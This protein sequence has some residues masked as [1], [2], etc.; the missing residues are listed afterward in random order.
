MKTSFFRRKIGSLLALLFIVTG[1]SAYIASTT[2][3]LSLQVS[4]EATLDKLEVLSGSSNL[5]SGF[6]SDKITYQ[7][8]SSAKSVNVI[9]VPTAP[10]ATVD[11]VAGGKTMENP[12]TVD[13]SSTS[14]FTVVVK[15]GGNTKTYTIEKD[16]PSFEGKRVHFKTS[17]SWSSYGIYYY[18]ESVSP[19]KENAAWASMPSMQSEGNGWYTY[20][21]TEDWVGSN[22]NIIFYGGSD[23]NRYPAEANGG[24]PMFTGDEAWFVWDSKSWSSQNPDGPQ[25]P[26]VSISPNG[27]KVRGEGSIQV[28]ISGDNIT[29]ISATFGS[30]PIAMTSGLNTIYVSEYLNDGDSKTLTVSATNEIGTTPATATFTRDDTVPEV[31]DV[32]TWENALVYFVLTDRF[33]NGDPSNDE[34]YNRKKN[35]GGHEVATFHGGDIKG[36][37][38]KLDYLE[39]LGVNAIWITAPYEQIHGWVSGKDDAFPHYAFHGY[40]T[41]D[42]TYMDKNMG[43]IEEF[44]TFVD[45]A[46]SR[47]IRIVMDV[48][49]N[50]TGYNTI[51]DM[52]TY[53]F[54]STTVTQHGW[55]Q[56]NNGKWNK[57]HDLTDY[58]SQ[59]WSKWW[60]GWAR[61]FDG[62]FGFGNPENGSDLKMSLAGLPDI[63]T[64]NSNSVAIPAFLK[65]KWNDEPESSFGPWR[66]PSAANLRS[67]N[68]GSPADY[69]IKWLAAWVREFGIDGFRCDTAKHIEKSRWNQLKQEG[70]AALNEWRNDNAK[71]GDSPAKEWSD[72]FWMTGECFGWDHGDISYFT[73]GGFDSMINFAF[74]SASGS[75]GRTPS[76]SDWNYYS[77]YCNS[78]NGRQVLSYVSSHDTGLH[79]PGDQ[80][81]VGTMLILCPGGVQI[82]YGDETARPKAYTNYSDKD[83]MTRGDMNWDAANGDVATHWKKLGTFRKNNPAVGAGKQT[84]LGNSTYGRRYSKNG[85]TNNVVIKLGASGST[86]VNVSGFFADGTNVRDAYTGSTTTVSG[87]KATFT[88]GNGGVILVEEV[89]GA[90]TP[91]APVVSANPASS[92]FTESVSVT[93][94]VNPATT[95]YY[96]TDGTA[97]TAASSVYSSALTFTSTTTLKTFV[98]KDGKTSVKTFTYTKEGPKAPEVTASPASGNVKGGSNITVTVS[99]ATSVSGTFGSSS[100]TLSNGTNNVAVSSY[101][102]D[103]ETK[104][105]SVSATNAEGTTTITGSFKRDDSTPVVTLSGDFNSLALYQVMVSSFQDGDPNRGYGYGWGNSHHNGDLRGIINALDYIKSL[106]VNAVW[107]TPIFDSTGTASE[108]NTAST[109]Y[110]CTDYFNVDPKFGTNQ[111]FKELVQK[112][113]E[114]GL[115]VILDGV[116]GHHGGNVKASPSGKR[117][118][119]GNNP[120]DYPGSLDFYKEV[121]TYWINEFEIDGWRLDQCYQVNQGGYN[122]WKDIREAVEATC[123]SRKSQGKKWGILGYMVGEDWNGESKIQSQTYGGS[124]LKS[125]FDFPGRYKLVQT[126]A[127]EESGTGGLNIDNLKWVFQDPSN[128]GYSH[129][130]GSVYPNMFLTNHDIW[131]FGNLIKQKYGYDKGNAAYWKRHKTALACLAGYT[132]PITIYYGDEIGDIVDCWNGSGG[133]GSNVYGDNMARTNGQIKDFDSKQQDLYNWTSTIMKIRNEHPAM[134]RGNNSVTT[135]NG[136]LAN[137]KYDS[138][139][140]DKVLVVI[141]NSTVDS[142]ISVEHGGSQLVDLV[143]GAT[144][145]GNTI[146]MDALSARFFEVK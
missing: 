3:I 44:R 56:D 25:A 41:Q 94:S 23:S 81:N 91:S 7:I 11:I 12:A 111:D 79:R 99:N 50:H 58:D 140:K 40:Y 63:M 134:W 123:A 116:F 75:D 139:T 13:M 132:G 74:N 117:P 42:W 101:L 34:S 8:N 17:D 87:G 64:E 22:T 114:K 138:E 18:D 4:T 97:P 80:K 125:A 88:A 9:A 55:A 73:Q 109:G 31:T 137:I 59:E 16:G 72:S 53:D 146:Q 133:C 46:H 130:S 143:T 92:T 47:G 71:S 98:E 107:M 131:R 95:I 105:L 96:T 100:V 102:N 78:G 32:F 89:T 65:K 30:A 104:T 68:L 86:D 36:L 93:L 126:I 20:D 142:S 14:S 108:G 70:V 37:T 60:S 52:I 57:N 33:Y 136:I 39:D 67:D 120:V 77:N 135:S 129:S 69:I 28:S 103:G 1:V 62:K 127:E 110:F 29:S 82:F 90:P 49:V 43:T 121:A 119:G 113:H 35:V 145:T 19:T 26:S 6:S 124:G 144:V 10:N 112:A 106:G 83:M 118:S 76:V 115:Y 15:N 122:Y 5:I 21:M 85:Y 45:D 84:D 141:S 66:N 2:N 128:K 27:G 48:V 38:A 54:G 24:I 61:A 51:E